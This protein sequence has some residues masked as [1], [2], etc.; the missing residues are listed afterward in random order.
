[1]PDFF[2]ANETYKPAFT[3]KPTPK[4]SFGLPFP[5]A[6]AKHISTTFHSTRVF[7]IAS[8]SL[9]TNT[10]A[11]QKLQSALGDAVVGVRIGISPHT[12]IPEVVEIINQ[13]RD[14][15]VDCLVTL[16][17]GSLTDGAKLVRFALANDAF[18]EEAVGTLW[19]G[20]AHNPAKRADVKVP[21]IPL[22][23]IPTSLSGGEYQALAGA[24]E[25]KSRAKRGF[26]PGRDP[27]LVIQDPE[28]CGTTP[29]W[30]WLSSGVRAVDHCVEVLCSLQSNE[31]G[32]SWARKGLM[33]LVPGLLRSKAGH[34]E[35]VL[36]ARHLCQTGVVEAMCAVSAGMPLGASHA[37]G[38]QLG[39]LGVGHGE[40]SCVMLPAVCKFNAGKGAN[41]ER[42]GEVVKLLVQD[43]SVRELLRRKGVDV[44]KLDLGDLLDVFIVELGMPRTL[45]AVGVGR[46]QLHGLAMNSLDDFWSKTNP[47]P[48][49]KEEQM[50]EILEMVV[51]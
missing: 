18:T 33:K 1:M 9:S 11:L 6:C 26:E 42:Q 40:T 43:E 17:A 44:G 23:C 31:D 39:P 46:D 32:D 5:E 30:V 51:E 15:D 36:E 2:S 34:G 7:I 20:K 3:N 12:P 28:L 41:V 49:T 35:D 29:A 10:D 45:K 8:K 25:A 19:G 16:G 48:I 22:I 21:E 47:I 24:T 4:L 50:M 14:L 38:H 27:D 13:A 37:I